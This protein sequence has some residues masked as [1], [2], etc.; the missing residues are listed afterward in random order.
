MR[1]EALRPVRGTL[2]G[3]PFRDFF[4]S[5]FTEEKM[6]RG[7]EIKDKR[8]FLFG[9]DI[10]H[11]KKKIKV[12]FEYKGEEKHYQIAEISDSEAGNTYF[13]ENVFESENYLGQGASHGNI[14]DYLAQYRKSNR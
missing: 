2:D 10:P 3:R 9:Y 14:D 5:G 7:T 6:F 12:F 4:D 11:A 8:P 13:L 1:E